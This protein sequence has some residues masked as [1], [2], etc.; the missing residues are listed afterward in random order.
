MDYWQDNQRFMYMM[1]K[2]AVM[3]Y[4]SDQCLGEAWLNKGVIE[5]STK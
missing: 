1:L 5:Y 4:F 3:Q 2:Y